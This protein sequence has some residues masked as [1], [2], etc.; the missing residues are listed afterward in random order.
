M[1]GSLPQSAAGGGLTDTELRATA[2]PVSASSLPLPTGAAT[3]AK[4]P[5]LGTAGT[6]SADVITI[7]GITGGEPI[8]V[9]G[10]LTAS[11]GLTDTELR[12]TPVPVSASSLPLPTGAATET[13]LSTLLTEGAAITGASMPSGG[14]GG[15][16]WLSAIWKAITDRLPSS[17]VSG[18]LD[19]NVGNTATVTGSGGTFPVTDSGGS[20]TVDAPVGTPVYV[21]LS[22]GSSPIGILPVSISG[23]ITVGGTG[24]FAVQADTELPAAAP[25]S[26]GVGNPTAPAV[27]AFLMGWN[28][29]SWDRI[30]IVNTGQLK[31][32]L[33]NSSG[34]EI[35]PTPSALQDNTGNPTTTLVGSCPHLWD[36]T[37]S[38]WARKQ[39]HDSRNLIASGSHNPGAGAS[40]VS[41]TQT[42]RTGLFC[43]LQCHV[44]SAGTGTL[45]LRLLGRTGGSFYEVLAYVSITGG[46][47]KTIIFGPGCTGTGTA[48]LTSANNSFVAGFLPREW[49]ADVVHSAAS[50]WTYRVDVDT[51]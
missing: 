16:G 7:Q 25:L 26:E 14:S 13:T 2:V 41:A 15:F 8:E 38:V 6:P 34:T 49:Y 33:Y 32:T 4:Q 50:A 1:I 5:A 19:V 44:S 43:A 11:G 3:A 48:G 37:N 23:T 9:T 12:A 17:L 39:A 28:G 36:P 35:F 18:R 10:T 51:F 20:L 42:N 45:Q 46:G 24:S 40:E 30:D 29:A 27:G 21:R 31:A 47:L 22:D